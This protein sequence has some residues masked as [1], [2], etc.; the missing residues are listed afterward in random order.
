MT[1][2]KPARRLMIALAIALFLGPTV[3]LISSPASAAADPCGPA[4]N[5]ISCEN[6]KPGTDPEVWDIWEAGSDDIQGFATD[7]SVDVGGTIDFK[8]DTDAADY[9]I[10]IYRTGWY[11]GKGAR[12]IATVEPSAELPQVQPECLRDLTTD[13]YDCGNWEVSATWEVPSTAVSGVY[14]AKLTRPDTGGESHITF[15]VRDDTSDSDILFQTSDTTWHAY[16][17]YGGASFYQGSIHGRA[18]QLSYNRP[19]TTRGQ[20]AGRDF[21]FSSEY[22][23]VRFLE[24]NGYDVSYTTD[25]DSDRRGELIQNHRVFTST[26]HDEYWSGQQR[27]NIEAARDAGVHLAFFTGNEAYWRIR[28]ENAA[29]GDP[30]PY[31]TMTSYKETWDDA[32]IDPSP[33]WTGTWRD[34][35]FAS[36]ENGGGRPENA[37]TGTAY[38]VNYSDLPVTVSDEEGKLRLW[39]HT[40]L[41]SLAPGTSEELAPHTIGYES[42]ED[43]DNGF[44]PEG[45]IRLS[46]TVGEVPEYLQDFGTR[47]EPGTTTHHTTLY[48]ADSGALVF[49][50]ASVQWAWGLDEEHDGDG[51]PADP[52][53]QQATVNLLADMDTQP[54]TLQG[55]LERAT[56]STDTLGPSVT[57][58]GPASGQEVENGATVTV[59]GTAA[60]AG[61]GRVAGVEVSTDDGETWHPAEGTTEWSYAYVQRGVGSV[62]VLVRAIDDSANIGSPARVQ[63]E[64]SCPCSVFGDEAPENPALDDDTAVELGLRFTAE[65]DGFASGVRFYQGPGNAGPHVG[66]L[67]SAEGEQLATVTFD[68]ETG[69]GWRTARFSSPVPL[70]AGTTYVVSYTAP[71]GRY[72]SAADAFWYRGVEAGPV[73]VAGGYG[74]DPAGVYAAPGAFPAAS[75][76]SSNYFVDVLFHTVD[77]S[78]LTI[79]AHSPRADSTSVAPT[80]AIATTVSKPVD[81]ASVQVTLTDDDGTTVPGTVDY[82]ESTRRVTFTPD[83]P[84]DPASRYTA[85]VEARDPEGEGISGD[86]HWSFTT[87]AADRP[88]GECPCS[89]FNESEEPEVLEVP[90]AQAVTLGVRLTS[91]EPGTITAIRFYKGGGNVGTHTGALW[92]ADGTKLA[93]ATFT[94]ESSQGWQTVTLDQPVA[95]E[96]GVEYIASYRTSVG[97]YSYTAGSFTSAFER[98]PLHVPADGGAYSYADDFPSGRTAGNYLVDVVFEPDEQLPSL[99]GSS[100]GDGVLGVG[101]DVDVTAEF[102]VPVGEG[103]EVVVSSAEGDVE[104]VTTVSADGRVVTFDPV[105]SLAER[106]RYTVEVSGTGG[107]SV[108]WDF[109]TAGAHG[110]PCTVFSDEVPATASTSDG[111]R[112]ELG[113]EFTPAEPGVVTG[114]RFYQGPANTG[115]HTGTLWSGDGQVLAT[116]AFADEQGTGWRTA[117]FDEPVE[118]AAGTS[119]VVSYLAPAGGYSVTSDYFA[120]GPVTAGPLTAGAQN[121]RY[122]YGGGFPQDSYR[123]SNYFVDPIFEPREPAPPPAALVGSSPGDGVLGVGVD[124]DVTAEFDVPVGEGVEVVVS[125]AEGDV[126]GV[127]T[128][129]ADGR[130]VTFDPVESLAERTRYTVEVSGTGGASVS[131]DFETAGAHGCP[132]TVFSDEVPATASTSDGSRV[133]L[134]MEFT[135]AEPGVVTGV[136]FYQGPANT[137]SHTG[138]LWSGDGQV[139][140][141]VAFAD[142]QGT[143]WRTA[144]FDEPVEVAAGTSYVVSYLAPAGGYSVTSDYF[145]AGPV[146]AGPL[147]AGAQNGRYAYGGGFPQDSYRDSNYFVDPIFEPR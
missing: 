145:A 30:T 147:T 17:T 24:R 53:M 14:V 46:T 70:T 124:V 69:A 21:Y 109:E 22:A 113:M 8:I 141:T 23:M 82:D 118:V 72:A 71:A 107:A 94:D 9:T 33:Q 55:D 27:A 5:E 108:S 102:D 65:I 130:V 1:R 99:V 59:S 56:T 75:Y 62:P 126:E 57:I 61:G 28:W 76:G 90:E 138:T 115:S 112:V 42:N 16:N 114:V 43:L 66:S 10:T 123:D 2:G 133:E 96:D 40:D 67:W 119:Y 116:V 134:G 110:C 54:T 80:A 144:Y 127:T 104:G 83:Q 25:V 63:S 6:S 139:L 60:D 125:S 98:G 97:H 41:A 140:A 48:R 103:V 26:G 36:P 122:A 52:R 136:R 101:V 117:Y 58:T 73:S 146:T 84:L 85:T 38:M 128:V 121:G 7:I 95:V 50:S 132:C 74:A 87:A 13:L 64:V 88:E 142:E 100:P 18:Y 68:E 143:G 11:Q 45:L 31:R 51:A 86:A 81:P 29:A 34:P 39:R 92:T 89:L 79:G 35:R 37:L 106:T 111:S 120:A 20:F 105:E 131:W 78:P 93:E 91:D 77:D 135:P 137:G 32:K 47:V 44:R 49:S 15:V 19:F 3:V 4:G 12:Q 129:S